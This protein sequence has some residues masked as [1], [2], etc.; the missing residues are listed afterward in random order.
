[1]SV[2]VRNAVRRGFYLDSV[3]LMRLSREIAAMPGVAQAALMMATPANKA[4]LADA[5]LL[6]AEGQDATANDLILAVHAA[7]AEVAE[8]A[9][10]AACAALD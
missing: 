2:A 6:A 9:F 8:E 7:A 10:Q 3:V 4:I 5:G 1:M